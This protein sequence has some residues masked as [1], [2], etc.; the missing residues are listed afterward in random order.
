MAC[1]FPAPHPDELLYSILA[2][3]HV[4]SGNISPKWTLDELFGSRTVVA[5][6]DMPCYIDRLIERFPTFLRCSAE[7]LINRHTLYPYY[8]AFLSKERSLDILRSMRGDF[9][10]DVHTKTGIMASSIHAPSSLMFCPECFKKDVDMY[11]EAYWHRLHQIPGVLV[12]HMHRCMLQESKVRI[13]SDNRHE[14]IFADE[15]NCVTDS[16]AVPVELDEGVFD[17][18]VQTAQDTQ[19]LLEH[20]EIV[21]E[22]FGDLE[23]IRERYLDILKER[24][25]ATPGGRVYQER[26]Q[27]EFTAFYNGSFLRMMQS[28]VNLESQDN[29]LAAITRKQR[30]AFHPIRHLLFMRFIVG[31]IEKFIHDSSLNLSQ[32]R[33]ALGKVTVKVRGKQ[34]QQIRRSGKQNITPSQYKRIDWA[35]RDK[36]VLEEVK[37]AVCQLLSSPGKPIRLSMSKIGKT[38]G[39][40]GLLEQHLS[41]CPRQRLI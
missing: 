17:M 37:T 38:A 33:D 7:E 26:L 13:H 36:E 41:K 30:K 11:G 1:F 9:G 4:W 28:E 12:C 40:L 18:L 14:F 15:E 24:G 19:Y 21:V 6:V 22:T 25:F 32:S 39:K 23:V 20:S 35:L 27:K 5:V 16:A 31:G 10:G 3:Y 2:R 34:K 8:T 29:W